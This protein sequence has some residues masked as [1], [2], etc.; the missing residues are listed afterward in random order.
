M[1]VS[2]ASD[3]AAASGGIDVGALY[4]NTTVDAYTKRQS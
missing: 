4:F 1:T 3:A 2:Y